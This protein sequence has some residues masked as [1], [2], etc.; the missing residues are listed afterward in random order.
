MPIQK[1]KQ[2]LTGF[3]VPVQ[4]LQPRQQGR[5]VVPGFR[6]RLDV[7]DPGLADFH[8]RMPASLIAT[9]SRKRRFAK[10]TGFR[11]K[12]GHDRSKTALPG[13]SPDQD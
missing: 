3:L 9:R 5:H 1:A 13:K 11:A 8:L 10:I 2:R 4:V 7:L 12:I 6:G